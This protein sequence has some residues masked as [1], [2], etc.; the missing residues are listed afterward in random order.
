MPILLDKPFY[1]RRRVEFRCRRGSR[2]STRAAGSADSRFA[3]VIEDE[4]LA[5]FGHK[6]IA[7]GVERLGDDQLW[8]IF[9]KL[10]S[11]FPLVCSLVDAKQLASSSSSSSGTMIGGTEAVS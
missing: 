3:G 2:P 11:K 9:F 4:N 10:K 7:D 6:L 8:P 1:T 5:N